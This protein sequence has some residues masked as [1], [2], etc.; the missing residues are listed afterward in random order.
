M[1]MVAVVIIVL[2]FCAEL[3]HFINCCF[4]T[5][6]DDEVSGP[7]RG[8]LL[9]RLSRGRDGRPPNNDSD[10]SS[11]YQFRPYHPNDPEKNLQMQPYGTADMGRR[12]DARRH[13]SELGARP[14]P[15]M[16]P[17]RER[18][19]QCCNRE[20]ERENWPRLEQSDRLGALS[21]AHFGHGRAASQE[22]LVDRPSANQQEWQPGTKDVY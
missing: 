12:E 19:E 4:P 3:S 20:R 6:T 5:T 2:Y 22:T 7:N 9:Y 18:R 1:A 13:V 10:D 8:S 16:V 15:A 11:R 21:A 14:A 17:S